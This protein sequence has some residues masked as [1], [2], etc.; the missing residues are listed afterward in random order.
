MP[1]WRW[2]HRV[3]TCSCMN[4]SYSSVRLLLVYCLCLE[5]SDWLY[6]SWQQIKNTEQ[7]HLL[8]NCGALH[9][10]YQTTHQ[11]PLRHFSA[12]AAAIPGNSDELP[13]KCHWAHTAQCTSVGQQMTSQNTSR[14]IRQDTGPSQPTGCSV[15]TLDPLQFPFTNAFLRLPIVT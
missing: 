1:A 3:E 8:T 2:P 6:I 13:Q 12:S 15:P 4:T 7:H 5:Q 10:P 11:F 14:G 9:C